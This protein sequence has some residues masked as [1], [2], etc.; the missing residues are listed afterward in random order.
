VHAW[1]PKQLHAAVR[2]HA[3]K[4]VDMSFEEVVGG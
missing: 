3:A 4:H 1:T 2:A